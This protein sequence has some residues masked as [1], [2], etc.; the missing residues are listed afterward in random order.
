MN[1]GT[2]FVTGGAG[3]IG[4]AVVRHL[5]LGR[6]NRVV[7]LD[8]LSYAGHEENLAEVENAADHRF[9]RIDIADQDAVAA[10][11]AE[12]RPAALLHL[13]AETHV[14]RSIDGPEAFVRTN[15]LG[16]QRLLEAT[17]H[18]FAG[19]GSREK[20]RF[21]FLQVSTDE[22]YGSLGPDDPAFTEASPYRPRSPYSASKAGADHLARAYHHTYGLPVIVTNCSNNYGPYQFPEKLIPL[23]ILRALAHERVPVYG[24]G[25]NIRDWLHVEDHVSGLLAAL[26]GGRQ[27]ETYLIGGENERSNLEV[28]R[29]V[30]GALNELAPAM[31]DYRDLIE[32]VPDRP[33]HDFRYAVDATKLRQQLGWAPER[34]FESGVL[35]TVGW[36]LDNRAWCTAVTNGRY[37]LERLG[38]PT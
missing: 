3:F 38:S 35:Q 28:V 20:E 26:E 32:F 10:L 27:G 36:Y 22:V 31:F 16:T 5:V 7:T 15:V 8:A 18:Y 30:L 33:G 34:D 17:R 29:T 13:A 9:V 24:D 19:L 1:D 6:G 23:T 25:S 14:D 4:S 11:L 12:E 21:R 37:G 2:I